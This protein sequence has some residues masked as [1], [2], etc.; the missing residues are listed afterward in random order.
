MSNVNV[1][2]GARTNTN[3][4]MN[5]Y[6]KKRSNEMLK[7]F[8]FSA[9]TCLIIAAL[10]L[11]FALRLNDPLKMTENVKILTSLSKTLHKSLIMWRDTARALQ[12]IPQWAIN[13]SL[14]SM[15][16]M[17][18]NLGSFKLPSIKRALLAGASGA[19][20]SSSM[21]TRG[22]SVANSLNKIIRNINKTKSFFDPLVQG[23]L[24]L[25]GA[26]S[27]SSYYA[28]LFNVIARQ[29]LNISIS[30]G[31]KVGGL[32]A[33]RIKFAMSNKSNKL[34]TLLGPEKSRQILRAI[35]NRGVSG[36]LLLNYNRNAMRTTN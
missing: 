25:M 11:H 33:N 15:S 23:G 27:L 4:N 21:Y 24:T 17:I 13:G 29:F 16:S 20:I 3:T 6:I 28:D 10:C 22:G 7:R 2:G 35:V 32:T 12:K 31:Y 8:L 14:T 9:I 18:I 36:T 1:Y 19:A 26:K 30:M 5:M 34:L